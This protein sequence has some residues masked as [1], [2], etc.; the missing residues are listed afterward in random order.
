MVLITGSSLLVSMAFLVLSS[1]AIE[2]PHGHLLL[3]RSDP[4]VETLPASPSASSKQASDK[5]TG[6]FTIDAAVIRPYRQAT[7]GAEVQ[8]IIEASHAEE[9]DPVEAGAVIYEISPDRFKLTAERSNERVMALE[10]SYE[11]AEQELKLKE[12]LFS[13]H[14]ATRQEVLSARADEKIARH[15][16]NEARKDLEFARR[17]VKKSRVRAPFKGHMVTLHRE[18]HEPVQRFDR[19]FLIADT[20]KVYAVVNVPEVLLSQIGKGSVAY[21]VRP[22][23]A[24]YRGTVARIGKA[25]DPASRTKKVHVLIDNSSGALEMGMLGKV[26]FSPHVRRNP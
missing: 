2:L 9:G 16:V 7:V 4:V 14:A 13:H 21:F 24:T 19:L 18:Q 3:A 12:Y 15:R 10:A 25:I 22:S 20:S 26:K 8:G 5:G 1:Q 11:R 6:T 17:D 23:G